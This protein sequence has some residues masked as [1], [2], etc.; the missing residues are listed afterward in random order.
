MSQKKTAHCW[1]SIVC[2]GK[3][4][5]GCN[6]LSTYSEREKDRGN[7]VCVVLCEGWTRPQARASY[8][9]RTCLTSG[10]SLKPSLLKILWSISRM[11][12][13]IIPIFWKGMCICKRNNI[14]KI[15]WNLWNETYTLQGDT[16]VIY[17]SVVNQKVSVVMVKV[18]SWI[19]WSQL[20]QA[21]FLYW[22][23]RI[24]V[25]SENESNVELGE[26]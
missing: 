12:I 15:I 7:V 25:K 1:K 13:L 11:K 16:I 2:L 21:C 4:P 23:A 14:C 24:G 10:K 9:C 8:C 17:I 26:K 6:N 19:E 3:G 22:Q 5:L 18:A 20:R